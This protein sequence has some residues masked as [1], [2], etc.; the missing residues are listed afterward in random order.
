[1]PRVG[2]I[3]VEFFMLPPERTM[4]AAVFASAFEALLMRAS[5]LVGL[6][7]VD[8]PVLRV[9]AAVAVVGERRGERCAQRQN[10]ACSDC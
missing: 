7:F 2:M 10:C 9:I 4:I 1:M 5:M 6:I 8:L 3:V